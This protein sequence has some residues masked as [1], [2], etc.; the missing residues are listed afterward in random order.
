MTKKLLALPVILAFILA[1]T[2]VYAKGNISAGKAKAANCSSCHGDDGNSMVATFPKLAGQHASYIVRQ[3]N[4]FKDGERNAAMMAALAGAL[5]EQ[6]MEDIAAY[7]ESKTISANALPVIFSDD[8]DDDEEDSA[9]GNVEK[10]KELLALGGELYRNGNE[11][12]HVAACIA[13]HGPNGEG[14]KPSSFPSIRSQHSDYLIKALTDFKKGNR[15]NLPDSMMHLIAK[16][17]TDKEIQALAF[18]ISMM[19]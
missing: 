11:K 8:D 5:S 18:Y 12:S 1:P 13:C 16:K 7:Y 9:E 14:N 3:L 15:S 17:M 10:V 6:D 2:V 4:D 19:R